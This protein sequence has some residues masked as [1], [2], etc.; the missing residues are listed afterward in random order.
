[1][2]IAELIEVRAPYFALRNLSAQTP[3]TVTA[4]VVPEQPRG[5]EL[6]GFAAAEA[7]RHLAIAGSCAC[8]SLDPAAGKRFYLANRAT[9]RRVSQA[10]ALEGPLAV[11]ATAISRDKRKAEAQATIADALGRVL[12]ALDV[13][14]MVLEERVFQRMFSAHRRDLRAQ[15]RTPGGIFDHLR[16]S[17]YQK[18]LPLLTT[19]LD[20][21]AGVALLPE[22]QGELCAGHFPMYPAMPVALLMYGLSSLSGEVL[23][24]RYGSQHRYFVQG[25]HVRADNLAFAGDSLRFEAHWRG[26]EAGDDAFEARALLPSGAVAGSMELTLHRVEHARVEDAAQAFQ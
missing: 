2:E 20:R 18:P 22:L 24:A 1:V 8:A 3:G 16:K 26:S 23:R 10:P 6:G 21:D 9:L 15:T 11:Q 4:S 14:Y 25:A 13:G 19:Q 5:H 7:G 17:P 12:F